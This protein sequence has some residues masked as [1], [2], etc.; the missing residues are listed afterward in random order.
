MKVLI[1]GAGAAGSALA[2]WLGRNGHEVTVVERAPALRPGGHA[3]DVRG[4]AVE[5][6]A[7]M[8]IDAQIREARTAYRGMSM[9]D[10]DGVEVFRDT[11]STYS[12][13]RIGNDDVELL[14]ADLARIL[15]DR[16]PAE[17]LF[18]DA[19]T[20]LDEHADGVRVEFERA[21]P[22]EFDLVIGA[23][24]L[25]SRVRALA[26]GPED[27]F[28]HLLGQYIGIYSVDNFLGLEDWQTWLRDGD[29]GYGLFTTRDNARLT[30][31]LGF[32]AAPFAYDHRDVEGQ[33]RLV[34]ERF[35][36][37][38]WE[39][40]RLLE[41]MRDAPDF[42]FDAVA[43]VRM[44]R[45]TSGRVALLG[46]AAY[47]PSPMSGQG[48][49]LAL[50]G[51]YVLAEELNRADHTTAFSRYETRMRPFVE[52]N[53]ALALENPGGPAPE[54]SVDKAKNAIAL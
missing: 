9:L 35:K 3:V 43:Q 31:F 27:E 40:P 13:G 12:G 10:G 2:F 51:A 37:A 28:V 22:R 25:H 8:G 42:Y 24:G 7:R 26:F 14:R 44:D 23:D 30:V 39:T 49:S 5:V 48:T 15:F 19:V 38:R 21:A 32:E 33:K 4:A 45:W 54:E 16:A 41:A 50:V 53:Q 52:A 36:D 47:C 6:A 11:E 34:A 17:Y 1:S 46:D 20:A 18:G 29:T